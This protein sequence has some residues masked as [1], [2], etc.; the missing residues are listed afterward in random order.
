LE[1]TCAAN[2]WRLC[3]A[4]LHFKMKLSLQ[5][6][7]VRFLS[8]HP[9]VWINGQELGDRAHALPQH[10]KHDTVSRRLRV[11]EE[12]SRGLETTPEHVSAKRLLRASQG[13]IERQEAKSGGKVASVFYRFVEVD[14]PKSKFEYF[15]QS[16]G[17]ML[18]VQL[19]S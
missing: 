14:R 12:A 19:F 17:S 2:V 7:L 13:L 10:Y 3:F 15:A 1:R 5:A 9:G 8:H 4:P 11:L 6:R 18:E 16:G